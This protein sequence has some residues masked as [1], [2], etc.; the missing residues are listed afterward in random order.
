MIVGGGPIGVEFAAEVSN[1]RQQG[2]KIVNTTLITSERGLLP[3]LP[4]AAGRYAMRR[5]RKLGVTII[6]GKV[7][8][9][10][11]PPNGSRT[12]STDKGVKVTADTI[13]DCTGAS[14]DRKTTSSIE[15]LGM[16][17]HKNGTIIVTPN[18][19]LPRED[20]QHVF[21][22]G[23]A[24]HV[25]GELEFG[26]GGKRCEK[27]AYAAEASGL[28]AARNIE[29]LIKATKHDLPRK[30]P[31]SAFPLRRFPRLFVISLYKHDGILSIGPVVITGFV[32]ATVKTIVEKL[33]I[34]TARE[35]VLAGHCLGI[36]EHLSFILANFFQQLCRQR[37]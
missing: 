25:S 9:P 34:A 27:T 33:S 18:L 35:K 15:S 8:L 21:V 32:A 36:M 28:V 2:N 17:T 12:V 4:A 30:Y 29:S 10:L 19:Q 23:D 24:A 5:L 7:N 37:S 3:R 22:A 6:H 14:S 1:L 26:P 11:E 31:E 13:F 16:K 20:F